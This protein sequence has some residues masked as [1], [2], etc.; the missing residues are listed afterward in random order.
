MSAAELTDEGCRSRRERLMGRLPEGIDWCLVADPRS[1]MYLSNFW[2]QPLSF[3]NG[4]RTVLLVKRDGSATLFADNFTAKSAAT[5]PHVPVQTDEWYNHK[6]STINRDQ[7]MLAA[8]RDHGL[9]QCTGRGMVENEALPGMFWFAFQDA[10]TELH[11][12][13]LMP[14]FIP[15]GETADDV[16]SLIR[17]MRRQKDGD[18]VALLRQ[19]MIA[20]KA[21][22][23]W[24]RENVGAGQTELDLYLGVAAAA[25]RQAGQPAV[26]YGDFRLCNADNPKQG[27]LPAGGTLSEGETF[28]LDYSVML[29]GYRS[30]FTNAYAVG[31]VSDGVRELFGICQQAMAG[32]EDRLAAGTACSDVYAAVKQPF[33]DAGHPDAFPHHAGHGLGLGHPEWP[34]LVPDSTDTLLAGDVVT[35][36][37]GAY[38]DGVGGMRIEHN[39]LITDSGYERLSDHT[40]ALD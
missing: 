23:D 26:V 14:D 31:S 28:V 8:F 3:S 33:V 5:T 9:P 15:P 21:G 30:D 2:L 17:S 11:D 13:S 29:A 24:A 25:Q 12:G 20:G 32:G 22:H 35:L 10:G 4:E 6:K 40:I 18:E 37:P 39:Y 38:V 34:T 1:V 7:S 16:G 19:C 36:E 27:G